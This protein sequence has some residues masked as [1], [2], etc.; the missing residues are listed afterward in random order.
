MARKKKQVIKVNNTDSLESLLQETYSDACD[1]ITDAQANITELKTS[2]DPEDVRD[3]AEIAAQK[4]NALKIKDSAI[5]IKLKI[6]KLQ[7]EILK[8][9]GDINKVIEN[10]VSSTA[11]N[12]D[13]SKIRKMIEAANAASKEV[14]YTLDK[15]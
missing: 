2:T 13:F 7:N 12:D 5:K 9:S 6:A 14:V 10:E 15:K 1:Q 4:T 8:N 11:T 3:H